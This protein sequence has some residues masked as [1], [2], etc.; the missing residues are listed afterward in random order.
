V[1]VARRE[2]HHDEDRADDLDPL[3]EERRA[4]A[5]SAIRD[6]PSGQDEQPDGRVGHERVEAE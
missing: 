4:A 1:D 3:E 2:E 5:I 6:D